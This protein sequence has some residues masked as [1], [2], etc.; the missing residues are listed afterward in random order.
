MNAK[1]IAEQLGGHVHVRIFVG[2]N[3]T[4]RG[5]AGELTLSAA[6]WNY[7]QRALRR[8][9]DGLFDIEI[10]GGASDGLSPPPGLDLVLVT[11][12]RRSGKSFYATE[13]AAGRAANQAY[14]RCLIVG[15][16]DRDRLEQLER[17]VVFQVEHADRS[18]ASRMVEDGVTSLA[19]SNGSTIFLT[20]AIG[21]WLRHARLDVV[22]IVEAGA[23]EGR[24][25]TD[26]I[27]ALREG[28]TPLLVVDVGGGQAAL[29]WPFHLHEAV[30][31]GQVCG[32]VVEL[33]TSAAIESP[34]VR[35][36]LEIIDPEA[37]R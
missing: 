14:C 28:S 29:G 6:E 30:R 33:G 19:V 31:L 32:R 4:S 2:R 26:A 15:P 18:I 17:D 22:V 8:G 13:L 7:W 36:L 12:P 9:A 16:G 21:T 27:H 35:R 1:L 23:V 11:G 37:A 34:A 25:A 3:R 10:L 24:V 5:L 20:G